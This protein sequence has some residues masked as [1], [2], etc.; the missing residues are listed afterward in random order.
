MS[1]HEPKDSEEPRVEPGLG[2][3]RGWYSR[4][5]LPHYNM[6]GTIQSVTFRLADSLPQSKLREIEEELATL[7][8]TKRDAE[9]R[10][11]IEAWLDAGIGCCAL[12]HPTL[13]GLMQET[14]L[15]WDGERYRL[16]A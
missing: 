5:Y 3:P 4:G 11:K 15:K 8:S 12:R 9:R 16:F 1:E 13:A 14:F 6:P 7:P 2:T 10:K